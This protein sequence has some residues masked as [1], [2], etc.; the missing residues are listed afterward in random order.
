MKL[1]ESNLELRLDQPRSDSRTKGSSLLRVCATVCVSLV[2]VWWGRDAALSGVPGVRQGN[3]RTGSRFQPG[4]QRVS[5][6]GRWLGG[7][8]RKILFKKKTHGSAAVG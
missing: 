1:K 3:R 2:R 4:T 6:V 7:E 8:G 5:R